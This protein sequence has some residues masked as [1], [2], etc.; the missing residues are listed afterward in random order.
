MV[1]NVVQLGRIS[2]ARGLEIQAELELARKERRIGDT[3]LLL[4][5]D[6]VITLGRNAKAKHLL[7]TREQLAARGVELY[8]CNRGGDIT[9]HGPGQ[10]VG[11]PIFNIL[12]MQPKLGAVAFMRRLEETMIR[13]CA[14]FGVAAQRVSG[15]TGV[16][17][18]TKPTR[19]VCAMGIHIS[20]GV[21][22]HGLALNVTT[23][24]DWFNLIVPCGISDCGVTSLAHERADAPAMELVAQTVARQ[25]GSVFGSQILWVDGLDALLGRAVGVPMQ[26]PK[27]FTRD[28]VVNA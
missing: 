15:R 23:E 16:W 8:E 21:T 4:E 22:T 13:T 27:V 10:L 18:R 7:A 19:K 1:I 3:L 12:E 25:F 11:Y 5:H 2:Y 6:P 20:R 9:F 28:H 14:E 24:L 26:K 17:T